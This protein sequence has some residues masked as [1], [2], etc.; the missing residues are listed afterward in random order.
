M[1]T[2]AKQLVPVKPGRKIS[3]RGGARPGAG[4]PKW[5]PA[6]IVREFEEQQPDGST[7]K[8]KRE[9]YQAEAWD[10][11]KKQVR[12]YVAIGYP[13]EVI[14]RLVNP[15]CDADTLRK[16]L[17]FELDNGKL[18]LDAKISGTLAQL[19]LQ[20]SERAAIYWTKARMGWR[21]GGEL[22]VPSGPIAYQLI[23]GDDW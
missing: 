16:H 8:I 15:P 12:H 11:T 6:K 19:A 3:R 20:G 22:K 21:D 5:H 9:E 2:A 4:G 1:A 10:R 23:Q 17:K 7:K 18:I 14:C 13:Q